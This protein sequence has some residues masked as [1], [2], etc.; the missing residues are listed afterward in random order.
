MQTDL[1]MLRKHMTASVHANLIPHP[2]DLFPDKLSR[3]QEKLALIRLLRD[4][5]NSAAVHARCVAIVGEA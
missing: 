2:N 3:V 1:D 4:E 5:T